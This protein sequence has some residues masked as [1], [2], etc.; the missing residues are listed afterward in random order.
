MSNRWRFVV[1]VTLFTYCLTFER[2]ST[3]LIRSGEPVQHP[4]EFPFIAF[5]TTERTMCTGSL[6][7]TRAVLTAGHCV[8]SP[9]PVIRVSF[10]TLRNGDQQ[11]IHHQPSG[12]KVAPGYMPSCM[13]ARQRRPIA[14]TLSGFDIAIVMLAQMVNLQSGIRVISLPQPSDI[15]PPGTGVFIVGYGRDD[16][17]R[18][19]S[20]KNGGILKKGRATIM[21]CRHATNG[22]PICVKAGQNF[23]QLPAPGDSGGPLLPSL[24]GPV[25]GVVSHGVTLPNLP[26]IIVEYAS[27]ARMLDFVRSNI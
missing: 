18:D 21:E 17:D 19:P 25:L 2:V 13:S 4:A 27:V 24:Q 1:V 7:S 10:L 12:V 20:R 16:N 14:Q 23:G 22:N 26:D 3:W 11:G 5:L 15:P 9:L 8:C 6:V